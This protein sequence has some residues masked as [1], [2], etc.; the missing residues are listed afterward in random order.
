MT[1][2]PPAQNY[3][4]MSQYTPSSYS[5]NMDGYDK[6][7]CLHE[8]FIKQAR[9]TPHNI[10]VVTHDG[11]QITYEEL[12]RLTYFLSVRLRHMG[13]K[14]NTVVGILMDRCLEYTISYIA[15]LRAGGAYL[16]LEVSYPPSLLMSVLEDAG[17]IAVCSKKQFSDRL[18][19]LI[20]EDMTILL[21]GN[22]LENCMAYPPF[23]KEAECSLD[24]MAYTV[25]SAGTTGKPKGI[26]CPHRGAVFSYHWR[27]LAYPYEE[28]ERE[29]CNVFF[30]WEMLRPLMKGKTLYI[31]P[32]DIIYDPPRLFTFLSKHK[33]T[34]MMFTPSL[35]QTLL[36]F[37]KD[38]AIQEAFKHMRQIWFCGEV[39]TMILR[40]RFAKIFP[41]VK[42]LNLYSVSECH[43]IAC[44]DLSVIPD[45]EKRKFCPVG[46]LLP[47]V[48]VIIMDEEFNIKPVA[49]PGEIY[50][51]GP[52]LAMGYLNRPDLNTTRFIPRPDHVPPTVGP[53]LYRT[54][55][56]GYML[57]DGNLEICGRC[58]SMIKIRGYSI[59]IQAVEAALLEL[60]MV[61]S[62][63]VLALG[64][65][66][67]DKFLVA[68][69]VPEGKTSRKAVRAALK[70]RLPFY[71]IPSKF[72]FLS[73][74]PIVEGS[75][76]LDKRALPK[77]DVN[78][79]CSIDPQDLP[80]TPMEHLIANIWCNI[81]R[82]PT[83]DVQEDFFDLGGHSLQ[84]ARILNEMNQKLGVN[85]VMSDLFKHPTVSSMAAF[86]EDPETV[87]GGDPVQLDLAAEVERHSQGKD[88]MD[89]RLRAFWRSFQLSGTNWRRDKVLLTGVT[90]FVGAFILEELLLNTTATVYCLI[91]G[92][93][94]VTLLDRVKKTLNEYGILKGDNARLIQEKLNQNV[95]TIAGDLTL[96]NMGLSD[97]EYM[98]LSYEIDVIIHAAATVN[99][100]YPYRALHGPNVLGTD[101]ILRFALDNKIKPIHYISTNA[102]YP[103]GMVDCGEDDDMSQYA[104][105]LKCGYAQSKWVAEQLVLKLRTRGHPVSIYRCGNVS[106]PQDKSCWNPNDFFLLMLQSCIYTSSAPNINWQIEL[107]PVDFLSKVIVNMTQEIHSLGKVFNL[108]NTKTMDSSLMWQLLKVEG[109]NLE[110]VPY[111]EWY[112]IIKCGVQTGDD[113]SETLKALL[114][115][116]DSYVM[117]ASYFSDQSTFR[118]ENLIEALKEMR[119]Q[120]PPVNTDLMKLYL[121]NLSKV[122]LIPRPK[123]ARRESTLPLSGHVA[124]VTGASS[125]I[126][127]AIAESLA[128]AGAKVAM[129]A[130]R[131]ERLKQLQLEIE[132]Q[133]AMAIAVQMDVCNEDEVCA[134]VKKTESLLG[135][136]SILVNNA[137][138]MYYTLM[139]NLKLSDWKKMVDVN[140]NGVLTCLSAVLGGMVDRKCGHIINI[141]SDAGRKAY[142]GLAVYSGTKFFIEALSRSLREE[143]VGTGIKVTC[144][145]PGDVKTELHGHSTDVEAKEMYDAS[146]KVK[147][148]TPNDVAQAVIYALTQPDYCAVNEILLE[149]REA[150][151]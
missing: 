27:H 145:Q 5:I 34:R 20:E 63:C 111:D 129:A 14:K 131:V 17:P 133:G 67:S 18:V 99:L 132:E 71:M 1:P 32:D 31:V 28:T 92:A 2:G 98:C 26:Q 110:I 97:D 137:G 41:Q 87:N 80:S 29:A 3:I 83:I 151:I 85:L 93:P 59:E 84:A 66:G 57:T 77:I 116:L 123:R 108:I 15:I 141:S 149:P 62:G 23:E 7:G 91:R 82:I 118:Q 51:G 13:V 78:E 9:L 122:G 19:G 101:N 50:V 70:K 89:I 39:V 52:T 100:I 36:D 25:Y 146:D 35:L 76:K 94:G 33:I 64:E 90:G 30:V 46:K 45:P 24:N 74:T 96:L 58:D 150:P 103:E 140:I 117:D 86:I 125:G 10:A 6:Q 134:G 143:V 107:T 60:P 106:G 142:A 4:N 11:Q 40:D 112:N 139:K 16:P 130:R 126:G 104:Q 81:L 37:N 102:V 105:H 42:M 127:A 48:H 21:E 68:Y 38:N 128:L 55:D 73:S 136:I 72:F 88:I 43:D 65:E 49:V 22:W 113:H 47:G 109:Y 115:L 114:Y 95:I 69:I 79:D 135:P 61:N 119:L 12:D 53:R 147:I 124:L 148:L 54:G 44:A 75:G 8:I 121:Q 120:Y 144:I 138:V 56:W